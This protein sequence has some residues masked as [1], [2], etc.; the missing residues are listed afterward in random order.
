MRWVPFWRRH[1][2]S[3]INNRGQIVGYYDESGFNPDGNLPAGTV[4]GFVWEGVRYDSFTE[5]LTAGF[6]GDY[7]EA[8]EPGEVVGQAVGL[9]RPRL[10]A[11]VLPNRIADRAAALHAGLT[12][13]QRPDARI[14]SDPRVAWLSRIMRWSGA[15]TIEDDAT[16]G[17]VRPPRSQLRGQG[18]AR[19]ATGHAARHRGEASCTASGRAE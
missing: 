8:V 1:N 7:A 16:P 6:R 5:V 3:D 18:G 15:P 4:H 9:V 17:G 13:N 11:D 2:V 12:L 19:A 14:T 10:L